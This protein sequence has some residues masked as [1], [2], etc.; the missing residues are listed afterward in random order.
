[1]CVVC[2]TQIG[3][4]DRHI[5]ARTLIELDHRTMCSGFSFCL[6]PFSAAAS[7]ESI[8]ENG[9]NLVNTFAFNLTQIKVSVRAIWLLFIV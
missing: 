6:D 5:R 7:P 8:M 4:I 3:G 9:E 2:V 1:M